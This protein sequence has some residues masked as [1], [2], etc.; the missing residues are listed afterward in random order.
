LGRAILKDVTFRVGRRK[1]VAS[2]TATSETVLL[3][4]RAGEALVSVP[5]PTSILSGVSNPEVRELLAPVFARLCAQRAWKREH[6]WA[7]CSACN[8]I[9]HGLRCPDCA[10]KEDH[11]KR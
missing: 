6:G 5:L 4:P 2:A 11:A 9:Y 3:H 7:H 10:L 1:A 8:R